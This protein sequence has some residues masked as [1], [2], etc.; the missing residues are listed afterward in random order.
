MLPIPKSSKIR[1][2]KAFTEEEGPRRC[3]QP[4]SPTRSG[5]CRRSRRRGRSSCDPQREDLCGGQSC[6][7]RERSG[8]GRRE[9][10]NQVVSDQ[11]SGVEAR[12]FARHCDV[13]GRT[14]SALGAVVAVNGVA[15]VTLVGVVLEVVTTLGD[16]QAVLGDDLVESVGATG[17]DLA[18]VAVTQDVAAGVLVEGGGPLGGSA[19]AGSV[20]GRHD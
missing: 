9:S 3:W 12:W 13:T 2:C 5:P 7:R 19:V 10:V 4:P 1:S 8:G 6:R 15:R 17:Q 18:G 20:V 14:Y 16:L 11:F